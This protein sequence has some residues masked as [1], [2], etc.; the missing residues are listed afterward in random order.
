MQIPNVF[1]FYIFI[2][3]IVFMFWFVLN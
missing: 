2:I 1:A 3:E